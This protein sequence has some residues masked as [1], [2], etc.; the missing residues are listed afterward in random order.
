MGNLGSVRKALEFVGGDL[1]VIADGA[2]LAKF[3]VCILPGVGNFGEGIEHLQKRN[4]VEPIRE[5]VAQGKFFLGVC[6]GMQMLLES[7][8]EAPGVPGLGIFKGAV[9]LFPDI[10]LKVPH[11]GWNQCNFRPGCLLG[12]HLQADEYFYFV[13]SYYVE[14]SDEFTIGESEYILPFSAAIGKGNIYGVQFHPEKSQS[15]GLTLLRNFID[16]AKL[17]NHL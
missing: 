13:H 11:M 3:D 2:R 7:S 16:E 1:E 8:E 6:L 5:F 17:Q 15:A 10:G 12:K 14:K 9:K 4:F